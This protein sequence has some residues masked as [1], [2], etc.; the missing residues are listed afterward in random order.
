MNGNSAGAADCRSA[1][2]SVREQ[3]QSLIES[4]TFK[5][6]EKLP[7]E[8]DLA[9]RFSVSRPVVR[10]ALGS[11]RAVG[12]IFSRKGRGSFV[13]RTAPLPILLQDRYS[14]GELHE[15]RL[16][17]ETES[18]A[19]AA[20]RRTTED[21]EKLKATVEAQ[22][23]CTDTEEWIQL[24]AAFHR[25]LGEASRNRVSVYLVMQL[26]DLLIEHAHVAL[27]V[28]GRMLRAGREHR[29]I[30]KA[31]EAGNARAA[32]REMLSHLRNSYMEVVASHDVGSSVGG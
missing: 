7:P 32:K 10:E 27:T 20:Q 26:Q 25:I 2:E 21:I 23:A 4:G 28:P 13:A 15:A 3:I 14:L 6:G 11:L 16:Y 29:A 31:V 22:E 12:L 17:L 1:T 9:R 5:L 8:I 24:D 19:V 18:A 30:Y